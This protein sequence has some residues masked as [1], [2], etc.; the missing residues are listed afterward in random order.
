MHD[1]DSPT[2]IR[3]DSKTDD[4]KKHRYSFGGRSNKDVDKSEKSNS[5]RSTSLAASNGEFSTASTSDFGGISIREAQS[6]SPSGSNP[7]LLHPD[8]HGGAKTPPH[9]RYG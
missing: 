4:K 5:E 7:H 8:M 2:S 9:R 3:K 6:N 1:N